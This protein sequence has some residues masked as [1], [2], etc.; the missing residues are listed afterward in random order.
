MRKFAAAS[1]L[2]V[3]TI[4]VAA[5]PAGWKVVTDRKKTCQVA[6]PSDWTQDAVLVGTSTSADKKS[7]VVIR[8]N[9]QSLSEIKPMIQQMVPPDS[10][11]VGA[12]GSV[13][14]P[15]EF[16]D[17]GGESVTKQIVDTIGTA[18]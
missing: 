18:K 3:S 6:V 17:P 13:R 15:G 16:Q 14:L 8:G 1:V 5:V 7:N 12:W 9:E 4:V 2:D 10:S 11:R